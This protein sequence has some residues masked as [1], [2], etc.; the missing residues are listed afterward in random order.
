MPRPLSDQVVV[1]TG[2]SSG[3]GRVTA[4]MFADAGAAVVVTARGAADLA[5]LVDEITGAGGRAYGLAADVGDPE[6]LRE[7]ARAAVE[8]FGRI[9]TWVNNAGVGVF[10][11][12]VD[13]PPDEYA[14]VMRINYLGQVHGVLAA[15]PHLRAGGGGVIVGVSSVEGARGV[16]LQAPYVA[17][18]WALR[19]F[20]EVL[21]MELMA[22]GEPI[23]VTTVLPAAIDTPFYVKARSHTGW[24]PKPPP[25]VYAPEVVARAIVHAA[26]HPTR[27]VVVGGSGLGFLAAERFVPR[28]ADRLM[29]RRW[30]VRAQR[31]DLAAGP[32]ALDRPIEGHGQDRSGLP[33]RAHRRS[34]YTDAVGQHPVVQRAIIGGLVGSAVGTAVARRLVRR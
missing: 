10:G 28:I 11:K 2:G 12:A 21:R 34:V 15:V 13:V 3:I 29:A 4:R 27:D 25:P 19:G 30:V 23:A 16:P 5:S 7:V 26:R 18:K 20:Y 14:T 6:A 33:V 24:H 9:D 31:T 22:D 32:D 1:V 8:R 17:S